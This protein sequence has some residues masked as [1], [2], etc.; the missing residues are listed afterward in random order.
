MKKPI[1]NLK[2][3]KLSGLGKSD[4]NGVQECQ[5]LPYLLIATKYV[6]LV[7]CKKYGTVSMNDRSTYL[8]C[9]QL[10]EKI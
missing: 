2:I 9:F 1:F 3:L 5:N 8:F 6:F 7:K 4:Q 10:P